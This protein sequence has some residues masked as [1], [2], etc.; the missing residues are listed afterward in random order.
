MSEADAIQPAPNVKKKWWK[1]S[2]SAVGNTAAAVGNTIGQTSQGVVN[3]TGNAANLLG[4]TAIAGSQAV[5]GAVKTATDA[6][7]NAAMNSGR[8]V[9]K[10]TVN[11]AEFVGNVTVQ[12][13]KSVAQTTAGVATSTGA[14]AITATDSISN[15][16][17][18]LEDNSQLETI[19]GSLKMDWLL[20]IVTQ[21]D[22][23]K[24]EEQ[25]KKLQQKYP[26]ETPRQIANRIMMQKTLLVGGSGLASSVAPGAAAGLFALD[27]AATT[28]IQAE[29]G[30]Q[31]A[32]VY[33][34]DMH[35]PARGKEILGIFGLV[36]GSN[37]AIKSGLQLMMRNVPV[38]GAVVGAGTNAATLYTVG[39]M[40]CSFYEHK[41]GVLAQDEAGT[42]DETLDCFESVFEQQLLMDQIVVHVFIAGDE[43][44]TW[45]NTRPVLDTLN[46]SAA[47]V[48]K[49]S[50]LSTLGALKSLLEDMDVY[51]AQSLLTQCKKIAQEDGILTDEETVV[52]E[53]LEQ[54]LLEQK[55]E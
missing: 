7:T 37:Y 18:Y 49:L 39:H 46:L 25:V 11:T 28:A 22:I 35:D 23:V 5:S 21:V 29:M 26:N 43:S 4:N 50:A 3:A 45:E 44:R 31:I 15:L 51:F 38:A 8:A 36:F 47:S 9:S 16:L 55:L 13:G 30:Y 1:S 10:A 53:L 40:A 33:G 41:M 19:A 17:G 42:Q 14:M 48:E 27:L 2:L 24:A 6:T 32:G 12:A 20:P 34:L 54:K 52:L